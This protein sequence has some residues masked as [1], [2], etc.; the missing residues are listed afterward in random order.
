MSD[1]WSELKPSFE[2]ALGKIDS[3]DAYL[4]EAIVNDSL[5]WNFVPLEAD[6]PAFVKEWWLDDNL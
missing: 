2:S 4:A 5:R 3:L 6:D 1:R